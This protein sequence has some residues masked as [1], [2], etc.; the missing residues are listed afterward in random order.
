[1]LGLQLH[2]A[3]NL[4]RLIIQIRREPALDGAQIHSLAAGIV[5]DLIFPDLA[6]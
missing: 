1:M 2:A 6:D 4:F 5:F 3:L